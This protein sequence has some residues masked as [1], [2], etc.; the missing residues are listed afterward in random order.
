M[1]GD[2]YGASLFLLFI[3]I[4]L[5]ALISPF[6]LAHFRSI[7]IGKKSA[8]LLVPLLISNFFL[9]ILSVGCGH[10]SG[11]GLCDIVGIILVLI[12]VIILVLF[13]VI[14]IVTGKK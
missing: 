1:K 5:I 7:K 8:I 11:G 14:Y 12:P 9:F 13:Y 4:N 3:V 10:G 6:L 2:G